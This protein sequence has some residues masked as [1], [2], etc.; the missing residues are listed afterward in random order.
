MEEKHAKKTMKQYLLIAAGSLSVVLG[1]IGI[2]LP[3]LPTTP[4]VL[5]AA[6]GFSSPALLAG[7][8]QSRIFGRYLRH[9]RTNE[10]FALKTRYGRSSGCGS[11]FA[12]PRRLSKPLL[13]SS[14]S[15]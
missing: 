9:W 7:H 10:G 4:F 13:S 11:D 15:A 8:G 14:Y 3:V 12:S 5:L 6:A 2:I 1:G